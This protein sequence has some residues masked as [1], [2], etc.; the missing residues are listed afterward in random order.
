MERIACLDKAVHL[1][2]AH[3]LALDA[4]DIARGKA[5]PTAGRQEPVSESTIVVVRCSQCS[6][7]LHYEPGTEAVQCRYCGHEISLQGADLPGPKAP[8]VT[9]LWLLRR[10]LSGIGDKVER[11]LYCQACG[12]EL[13]L[14]CPLLGTHHLAQECAYCGS[15]HVRVEDDPCRPE[16]PDGLLPFEVDEKGATDAVCG[17]EHAAPEIK[18][19]QGLYVPFWMF[20]GVVEV[21]WLQR[22]Q[23]QAPA[24]AREEKVR[25]DNLLFPAVD[26]PPPSLLDEIPP[27]HLY[28]LVSYEAH[29]LADWPAQLPNLDVEVVVEDAYDALLEEALRQT[30]PFVAWIIR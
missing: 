13:T 9:T 1:E 28:K 25:Y 20:D 3:P 11:V 30:K 10:Y 5:S 23:G 24:S 17:A 15:P 7:K 22:Y 12:A 16:Q 19:L 2:P 27:F 26:I 21:R 8:S 29:F 6:G 18:A 4:L 14:S